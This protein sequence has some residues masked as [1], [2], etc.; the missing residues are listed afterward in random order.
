[1]VADVE[2][3]AGRSTRIRSA[4]RGLGQQLG[5]A[6]MADREQHL[7]ACLASF[8]IVAILR[9]LDDRRGRAARP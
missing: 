6:G 8:T 7:A 4:S 2:V 3:D 9:G 1:M 5:L